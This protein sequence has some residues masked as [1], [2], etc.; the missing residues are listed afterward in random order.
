MKT[1]LSKLKVGLLGTLLIASL[2]LHAQLPGGGSPAGMNAALTKL[3]GD[4]TAC[5][6]RAEIRVM[7]LSLTEKVTVPLNFALLDGSVRM[8]MDLSQMKNKDMPPGMV[9]SLKQMGLAQVISIF[10]PDKK[11]A[12]A[13]YPDQKAS[14]A[15]PLPKDEADAAAKAPKIEK[16]PLGK[17]TIDNHP[18]VKTKVK[19]V[20]D[21]GKTMDATAWY[22]TDLKDFPVQIQTNEKE[23]TT[24]ILFKQV[25]LTKP[26]ASLFE[27]PAGYTQYNSQQELMQ[28][29]MKRG[30]DA[31]PKK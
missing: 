22:A 8:E 10:R 23:G 7:D 1:Q 12:Y 29:I 16:T 17:E 27:P 19:I 18:C 31:A 26:S 15:M 6:A 20:D 21:Q 28:G 3:F 4:I 14:L 24:I 2:T 13:I 25:Q 9:D 5:S 30:V 11:I